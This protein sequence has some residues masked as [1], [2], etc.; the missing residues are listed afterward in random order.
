[1]SKK[2]YAIAKDLYDNTVNFVVLEI[3]NYDNAIYQK[4]KGKGTPTLSMCI[5]KFRTFNDVFESECYSCCSKFIKKRI[6]EQKA[7]QKIKEKA[8]GVVIESLIA[9]GQD[10]ILVKYTVKGKPN[11]IIIDRKEVDDLEKIILTS[12]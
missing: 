5:K 8:E 9:H 3:D 6:E 1:M 10:E 4:I 2:Y 7:Q 11:N 12:L